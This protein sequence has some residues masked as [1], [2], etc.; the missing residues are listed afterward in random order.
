MFLLLLVM[1]IIKL[2]ATGVGFERTAEFRYDPIPW[3]EVL[4]A[5]PIPILVCIIMAVIFENAI[6]SVFRQV[7][8]D[9]DDNSS[10][11]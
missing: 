9:T 8:K 2:K 5:M 6:S 1:I 10:R 7:H 3:C 4:R 11:R